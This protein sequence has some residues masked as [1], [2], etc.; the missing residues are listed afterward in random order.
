MVQALSAPRRLAGRL[1][2]GQQQGD[3]DADDGDHDEQLYERKSVASCWWSVSRHGGGEAR[4]SLY[5]LTS[6]AWYHGAEIGSIEHV[7]SATVRIS[8]PEGRQVI[9]PSVRAGN[10]IPEGPERPGGPAQGRAAYSTFPE[11]RTLAR[12]G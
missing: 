12:S 8:G 11:N 6:D 3:Q 5:K 4:S 9:A 10:R 1:D 2:G 7:H